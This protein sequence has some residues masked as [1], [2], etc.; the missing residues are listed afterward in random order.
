MTTFVEAVE[1]Q[2]ARTANGMKAHKSSTKKAVDFFYNVGASRGKDIIPAFTAA[3]VEDRELALRIAQW[4]R[5]ARGGSGERK[6]FRDILAHLETTDTDAAKALLSKIPELGRWDDVFSF[7]TKELKNA[8]YTMLAD[9]IKAGNGLAAKWTP[10]KGPIAVE[11]RNFLGWSPKH[12]RKTLVSLT[13]VVETQ[14]CAND[15]DNINFSHVPSL[16]SAR[17]KKAFNRHTPKFAEYVQALIKGDTDVKVNAGAVYP[18]DVLKGIGSYGYDKTEKGHIVAQWDALPNFIG[19]ANILPLVDVSG[20]MATKAGGYQSKSDVTCMDVAVSLGLY[21]ADKNTGKFKDTF[22]TFSENPELLTLRGNIVEKATQMVKSNWGMSTNLH[23]AFDLILD[24]A[25]KFDVPQSEMPEMLLI[26][27]DMQFNC[28]RQYDDSAIQMIERKYAAAGYN[29]PQVVFWNINSSNNVPVE[30][31]KSGAA[32]VS[33]FSP[34]I[35]KA[36]L[37]A[38]MSDFTPEGIMLKTVMTERYA[39]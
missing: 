36:L 21:I 15:W 38:D 39:I 19:D 18:Y 8:A 5:D 12:Y 34:A 16:A 4:A 14:M 20:S 22:I 31:H 28:C 27:S 33:G 7:K 1:N 35:V 13:Q 23:T 29:V 17:Y 24:V 11:F 26:M 37:A 9:A 10:R 25:T 32:L 3:Y 2:E 30:S 6:L